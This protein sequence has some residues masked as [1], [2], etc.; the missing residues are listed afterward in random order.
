MQFILSCTDIV[1]GLPS[2]AE[3]NC[4]FTFIQTIYAPSGHDFT[5]KTFYFTQN[6]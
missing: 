4:T 2:L 3:D 5:N 6:S 1:G